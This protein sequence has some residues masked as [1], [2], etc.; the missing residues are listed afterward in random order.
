M[1]K[2]LLMTLRLLWLIVLITGALIYFHVAVPLQAHMGLGYLIALI[3]VI[4]GALGFRASTPLAILTILVGIALPV[5]GR[6]Q[7]AH[8]GM[9]DLPYIQITHV[10]L[11]IAAIG[12]AEVLGKRIGA[13]A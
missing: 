8:M 7:I 4:I 1:I 6:T 11:G 9:P 10:I 5:L 12:L 2:G 13:S 3:M